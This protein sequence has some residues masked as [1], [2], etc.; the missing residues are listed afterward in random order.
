MFFPGSIPNH[1]KGYNKTYK[2]WEEF[3]NHVTK[4]DLRNL[5]LWSNYSSKHI[6]NKNITKT[7]CHWCHVSCFNE[8]SS[9]RAWNT[10]FSAVVICNFKA[11]PEI[12]E[13]ISVFVHQVRYLGA[14]Y[15]CV[16]KTAGRWGWREIFTKQ[17]IGGPSLR[18]VVCFVS[19][20]CFERKEFP[21]SSTE[22]IPRSL[23]RT[24][25]MF[26]KNYLFL[27][28]S[29]LFPELLQWSSIWKMRSSLVSQVVVTFS[30]LAVGTWIL[31][32]SNGGN[33]TCWCY[34][35]ECELSLLVGSK[36]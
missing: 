15:Y 23:L 14:R 32:Y 27:V 20:V 8:T 30:L 29:V 16:E 19:T 7:W 13:M 28:L 2:E 3:K 35:E 26:L 6:F 1:Q 17:K 4:N 24:V 18:L 31:Q 33:L 36:G 9:S 34:L 10:P 5:L 25:Y 11:H 21:I 22:N 12:R